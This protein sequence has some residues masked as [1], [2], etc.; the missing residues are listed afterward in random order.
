[1]N[2]T[3]LHGSMEPLIYGAIIVARLLAMERKF[4]RGAFGALT[5]AIGVFVLVFEL[6]GGTVT[7]GFAATIAA[8]LAGIT[9]PLFFRRAS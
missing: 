1:M 4:T 6:H 8:L 2:V 5:V 3:L 9:F 7:G